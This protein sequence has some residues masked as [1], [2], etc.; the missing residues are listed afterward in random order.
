MR[1]LMRIVVTITIDVEMGF[2]AETMSRRALRQE[3]IS[4]LPLG[5]LR[6][7]KRSV[8]C[9]EGAQCA[10]LVLTYHTIPAQ[11][12]EASQQTRLP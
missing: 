1:D 4:P 6:G 3:R 5:W 7:V 12:L 8:R 9:A 10:L 11:Q 2:V